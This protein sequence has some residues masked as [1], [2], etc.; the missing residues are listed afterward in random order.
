MRIRKLLIA[1]VALAVVSCASAPAPPAVRVTNVA[2]LAGSYSGTTRTVGMGSRATRM[3]VYPTGDFEIAV[4][5]P[6]GFRRLGTIVVADSGGA[7]YHYD[8]VKNI[9]KLEW[10]GDVAVHEGDG[11]RV[12]VLRRDGGDMTTTVSSTVP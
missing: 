8:E 3:T 11:R 9:G 4:A 1:L 7:R 10:Q 2:T 5:D 12:L 6:E